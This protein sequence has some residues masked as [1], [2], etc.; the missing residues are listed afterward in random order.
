M[1]FGPI[2]GAFF[3]QNGDQSRKRRF[4]EKPIKTLRKTQL[5]MKISLF[6]ID[7]P[8][9]KKVHIHAQR[10]SSW[11]VSY[12]IIDTFIFAKLL[13]KIKFLNSLLKK[14]KQKIFIFE[15]RTTFSMNLGILDRRISAQIRLIA[16]VHP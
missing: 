5:F 13:P 7:S 2:V 9:S 1:N 11:I 8:T 12:R 6:G 16:V 15:G 10:V 3:D 14:T 4:Y